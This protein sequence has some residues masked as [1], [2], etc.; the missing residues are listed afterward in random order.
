MITK[1]EFI[2]NLLEKRFNKKLTI[3][4]SKTKEIN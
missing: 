3:K 1:K 4:Q 2:L